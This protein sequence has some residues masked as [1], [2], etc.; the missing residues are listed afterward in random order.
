MADFINEDLVVDVDAWDAVDDDAANDVTTDDSDHGAASDTREQYWDTDSGRSDEITWGS[1]P[2]DPHVS[3]RAGAPY[4]DEDFGWRPRSSGWPRNSVRGAH[5]YPA[6]ASSLDVREDENPWAESATQ[7]PE[8]SAIEE[9]LD[10]EDTL[11]N[12]AQTVTT[13]APSEGVNGSRN[14]LPAD[15][16][17]VFAY[18]LGCL[19]PRISETPVDG[20]FRPGE[21]GHDALMSIKSVLHSCRLWRYTT[22]QLKATVWGPL[23]AAA[24]DETSWQ[25]ALEKA[26]DANIRIV[27]CTGVP[28]ELC[29]AE[30]H[31][32]SAV[33]AGRDLDWRN[34]G[35]LLV[36]ADLK[37]LEVLYLCPNRRLMPKSGLR[38]YGPLDAPA[39]RI[40]VTATP[41]LLRTP[42]LRYL[43]LQHQSRTQVLSVLSGVRD[44]PLVWLAIDRPRESGVID[45]S[46]IVQAITTE[47]LRFLRI[48]ASTRQFPILDTSV[49]PTPCPSLEVA[50]VSGPSWL[51][52]PRLDIAQVFGAHPG[53]VL[54]MLSRAMNVRVLRTKWRNPWSRDFTPALEVPFDASSPVKLLRLE[55]LEVAGIMTRETQQFLAGLSAPNLAEMLMFCEMPPPPVHNVLVSSREALHAE[56]QSLDNALSTRDDLAHLLINTRNNLRAAG[57]D[58]VAQVMT[59]TPN[60]PQAWTPAEWPNVAELRAMT[61][62]SLDGLAAAIEAPA[63]RHNGY[64]LREVVRAA[65][66]ATALSADDVAVMKLK[67]NRDAAEFVLSYRDGAR[68]MTFAMAGSRA[69]QWGT[70]WE[71]MGDSILYA[72]ARMLFGLSVA[73]TAELH[74]VGEPFAHL[75]PPNGPDVD[76]LLESLREYAMVH[77]LRVDYGYTYMSANSCQFLRVIRDATVLPSLRSVVVRCAPKWLDRGRTSQVDARVTAIMGA[78]KEVLESRMARAGPLMTL[79][80]EGACCIPAVDVKTL[81]GW[82]TSVILSTVCI[83]AEDGQWC[84]VCSEAK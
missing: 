77:T 79:E 50:D 25:A 52:A 67:S 31:R 7:T 64:L 12:T 39:M 9:G 3:A 43:G 10:P 15:N 70:S 55:K 33:Y 13:P 22:L 53:E 37:N 32:A 23:V 29:D 66:L 48:A 27:Y 11:I 71:T 40:C 65:M 38:M 78:L 42:K 14:R 17:D 36:N 82:V 21:P 61:R 44:I 19:V 35:P 16:L 30:L 62:D 4:E 41:F 28:H 26:G 45:A 49:E 51:A 57:H 5:L 6:H 74:V 34:F 69:S 46:E 73:Q 58:G 20:Y 83:R 59:R 1:P 72:L 81:K 54:S 68:T 75:W 80:L 63:A 2:I 24:R 8:P 56:L 76:A 84:P 47:Q 60:F 18:V